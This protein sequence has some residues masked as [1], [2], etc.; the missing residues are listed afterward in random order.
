MIHHRFKA[1]L[2]FLG[3]TMLLSCKEK[4]ELLITLEHGADASAGVEDCFI[5]K[6]PRATY[7]LEKT[8]GGLSSIVDNDGVDWLGFHTGAG[9][10]HKGEYRGFPNAIHKQD[11]SYFHAMN[12]K[13]DASTCQLIEHSPK[14]ICISVTSENNQWNALWDFYPDHC[15]FT[16]KKISEGYHYWIQYEGVPGGNMDSTDFWFCSADSIQHN[17]KEHYEGDLPYPEWMAFGDQSSKRTL[18]MLHHEDDSHPDNYE[19]RE[20][21]TVFA[22]GRENKNKYLSTEQKF[23]IG[24]VES[25]E[26]KD[27]EKTIEQILDQKNK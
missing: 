2:I 15:E 1:C 23:S 6:T 16:M 19:D 22:F 25:K 27:I 24:F 10:A 12:E 13:T 8:G 14:H 9:T 5:I 7:Y 11:G 21:M 20:D 18:F 3:L 17:I 4:Q 26:Y